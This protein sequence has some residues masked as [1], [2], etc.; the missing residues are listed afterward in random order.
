MEND[1]F[2]LYG[3]RYN[4]HQGT[5]SCCSEKDYCGLFDDHYSRGCQNEF[6]TC[7]AHHNIPITQSSSK[8]IMTTLPPT[9]SIEFIEI[10]PITE[11]TKYITKS[12]LITIS[13]DIIKCYCNY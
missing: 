7:Y 12:T 8:I 9:T 4:Y 3:N 2:E 5:S 6:G 11:R 10:I 1:A 13:L